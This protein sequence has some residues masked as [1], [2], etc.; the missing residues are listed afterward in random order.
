MD[1]HLLLGVI[2]TLTGVYNTRGLPTLY[3]QQSDEL[4]KW[5]TKRT[6]N[7]IAW[8]DRPTHT[9][10]LGFT[11][12]PTRPTI[13]YLKLETLG[14][15]SI[16]ITVLNLKDAR[17]EEL[18]KSIWQMLYIVC[19]AVVISWA[20]HEYVLHRERLKLLF[21]ISHSFYIILALA[22]TGLLAPI[23]PDKNFT[24]DATFLL[25]PVT[26][27][28]IFFFHKELLKERGIPSWSSVL[29]LI[30]VVI[31]AL[32]LFLMVLFEGQTGL[33]LNS[34]GVL[35]GS[36]STFIAACF[37][38]DENLPS[39]RVLVIHY[40]LLLFSVLSHLLPILGILDIPALST[41]GVLYHGLI[42]TFIFGH[43]MHARAR[44]RN[45]IAS[46]NE[47]QLA[48]N[49]REKEL[50]IAQLKE[51][52]MFTAMLAHEL[53]NPLASISF[54][55]DSFASKKTDDQTPQINRIKKA[56]YDIDRLV[57]LCVVNDRIDSQQLNVN[58]SIFRPIETCQEVIS[59]FATKR[60]TMSSLTKKA[61][62]IESD[63][64]LLNI[65]L[66]NLIKNGLVHSP[67]G[68]TVDI[69][70]SESP[71]SI[72]FTIT[73]QVRLPF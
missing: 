32:A 38:K 49:R 23:W 63:E 39:K 4:S 56:V 59:N 71:S 55:V 26:T 43:Y 1:D 13:Y 29:T 37:S 25:I 5:I 31:P 33:Q 15:A 65:V 57:K 19:L 36:L 30:S 52:K 2:L 21:A 48:V 70:Y 46:H 28:S 40:L 3:Q 9:K 27:F 67:S 73:N 45:R 50:K 72:E 51:Q 11:V 44:E 8:N 20:I 68:A 22:I 64:G 7:S 42:S 66:T 58:I 69:S 62:K 17:Q 60:I 34:F 18:V 35:F 54:S 47:T 16:D 10:D 41:D 14:S 53:K 6:G 24:A 61:S 12:Q